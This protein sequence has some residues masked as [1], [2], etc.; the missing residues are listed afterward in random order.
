MTP[1]WKLG[2]V[3]LRILWFLTVIGHGVDQGIG[4]KTDLEFSDSGLDMKL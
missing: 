3:V 4:L 2:L 1:H